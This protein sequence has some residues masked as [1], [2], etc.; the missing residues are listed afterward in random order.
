MPQEKLTK[1]VANE[2]LRKVSEE[3]GFNFYQSIDTP[4]GMKAR[5]L[6]EFLDL[7][8]DV[9]PASLEFHT[10]RGDFG[11]WIRMLG[12]ETLA[13]QVESLKN[14]AL[15]V[16]E[17]RKRLMLLTRLRVGLLRKIATSR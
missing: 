8:K 9:E 15:P 16:E 12:D 13:K 2:I 14:K 17:L 7:L 4:V 6:V 1:E 5:S 10:A 3:E 11:N